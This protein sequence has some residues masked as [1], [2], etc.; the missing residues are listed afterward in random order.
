MKTLQRIFLGLVYGFLYV[1]IVVLIIYSF[2]N[3]QYSMLWHGYTWQWY[4]ELFTDSDLI[5]SAVHSIVLGVSAATIATLLGTLCAS[6]LYR[7]KFRG[8]NLLYLT[9]FLMILMP[10]IVIG[11]SLLVLFS[12]V[13][14]QMGYFSLLIA[15]IT[16]CM[17]FVV[18]IIYGRLTTLDANI[19][20]AALD[21]GA[22][23][24]TIFK[25]I[26]IPL[27]IPGL[28]AAWLLSFTISLDDVIISYFVAG[29]SFQILPLQIFSMVKLGVDPEINALTS[30]IF[31][32]TV[33][34]VLI[35]HFSLRKR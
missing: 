16:L 30:I 24:A 1:P 26:L 17:P 29:P 13:N 19:F 6:A 10:D 5:T 8:R 23:N 4:Q 11:T 28:I 34:L 12:A 2:N 33:C 15:H 7:Y 27:L 35:S 22:T 31:A 25:R 20:E 14:F 18:I 32:V 9:V 21:L 3:S